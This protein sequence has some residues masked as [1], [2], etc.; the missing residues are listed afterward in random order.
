[1]VRRQPGW[2]GGGPQTRAPRPRPPGAPPAPLAAATGVNGGG[3]PRRGAALACARLGNLHAVA[4]GNLTAGRAWFL[5]AT[6]LIEG[7]SPCIEQGWVAVAAMGCD[8][9]D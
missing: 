1:M 8:V 7:E 3:G 9:D 2:R 4:L 6:R 5:R